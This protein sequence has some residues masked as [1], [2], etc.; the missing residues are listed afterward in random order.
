[1]ECRMDVEAK[2]V[3]TGQSRLGQVIDALDHINSPDFF[4]SVD[5]KKVG[6]H[7]PPISQLCREVRANLSNFTHDEIKTSWEAS[8]FEKISSWSWCEDGWELLFRPIP[9][10]ELRNNPS[11]RTV[12]IQV[13]DAKAIDSKSTLR[14]ALKSKK[15]GRYG[16]F[17][18]PYVIALN[19]LDV[20]VD[21][22]DISDVL[23]G[24]EPFFAPNEQ[25]ISAVLIVRHLK[26]WTI[27]TATPMLW[28]NPHA[29]YTLNPELWQGPQ[30]L[31]NLSDLQRTLREGKTTW[32]ILGLNPS[33]P[34][35]SS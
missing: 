2:E 9:K 29:T 6:S 24:Y 12:G 26:P 34:N 20:F 13:H 27:A 23:F 21:E 16:E 35:E 10:Y 4:L 19:A 3:T 11:V 28:H 33:W 18:L 5:I 17:T 7:T 31:C 1:M 15:A 22:I 32:Q 14:E 30:V 25:Q 8:G